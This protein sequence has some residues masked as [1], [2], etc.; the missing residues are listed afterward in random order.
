[1]IAIGAWLLFVVA[2]TVLGGT[3]GRAGLPDY[4]QGAGDS[5]R[6]EQILAQAHI[7]KP[8]TELVLVRSTSAAVTATSLV[9]RHAVDRAMAEINGTGLARQVQ[10]PYTSHLFSADGRDALIRF[11]LADGPD[12]RVSTVLA[13]VARAQAASP[14][15][16]MTE[17]GDA[18]A[19]QALNN[20]IGTNFSRAEWTAVPLAIGVLLA[21]FGA[22]MAAVLPVV[23][24]LTAF[25]GSAGLA[26]LL[27][28]LVGMNSYADS[29]MLLMGLAVGVDYSLFYLCRERQER[30]AGRD[31]ASAL[32]VAAATSGRSVLVSG[33][34]VMT[35]MV[36]MLLSGMATFESLGLAAMVVVFVAML[37]SVTVLPAVLSLLGD[38][39]E[40]GRIPLT[41]RRRRAAA[42]AGGPAG[43]GGVWDFVLRRVLARPVVFAVASAAI[44]LGLAAPVLGMHTQTLSLGQLLPWNS[45]QASASRQIA[46]AFPGGPAP[47]EI[48]IKSRDIQ[49]PQVRQAIASFETAAL[50]AGALHQ[51]VQ[52]TVYRAANVAEITA[53][54]PGDGSD[55][56]SARALTALRERLIPQTLGRVPGTQALT[57]GQLAASLDYNAALRSAAIRAFVFVMAAAFVLML[58]S[59]GS[60][61]IAA[62][63]VLLDL[64]SVGAAYG[65]M[66]AIFQHGW[67]A[68]LIGTHAVGAIESWIPLFLFVVLFGLSMDYHVFV[69]SRIREARNRGMTTAQAV[70]YGIRSTAGVVTS[71]AVIMVAVF[72]VFGTLSMQDFKQLGVGL[73]VA[74]L[75]D[76][77]LIRVVLLP[78]VMALLGDRNWYL[79]RWLAWMPGIS[80]RSKGLS[81][82]V[83]LPS[84]EPS[85]AWPTHAG[86]R[87]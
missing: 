60:V 3:V 24:A 1:M 74:I 20:S 14:G 50:H 33:L 62:T 31:R 25:I 85:Q 41:G 83:G 4:R 58:A 72:A 12:S 7:S 11:N 44:L 18:S 9:F 13:A 34:I 48:V 79:P 47:A 28:H 8:A 63:C 56:A 69:V 6:A 27:S 2:A 29:V 10:N 35:G 36:G 80:H 19:Q 71:A 32:R 51:P 45:A 49:A 73:A 78:S 61:V 87:G 37:G 86:A 55:A 59:L 77:T 57:D 15:V 38:R 46:A 30:V 40:I 66:T 54:L 67:G 81:A 70:S 75:L 22:L 16:T 82:P 23:L 65:V 21:V 68:A 52:F 26:D 42:A 53:P 64:L 5:A 84:P 17:T 43:R 76:A 39:V